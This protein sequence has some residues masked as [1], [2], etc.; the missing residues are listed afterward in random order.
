MTWEPNGVNS[1]ESHGTWLPSVDLRGMDEPGQ[2]RERSP[3]PGCGVR[4]HSS[5]G[6]ARKGT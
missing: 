4:V 6:L 1:I 2:G 5:D 3:G